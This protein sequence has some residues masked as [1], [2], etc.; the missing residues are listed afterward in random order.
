MTEERFICRAKGAEYRER[1]WGHEGVSKARKREARQAFSME[2]GSDRSI[3]GARVVEHVLCFGNQTR[4][5]ARRGSNGEVG[6][7]QDLWG[8]RSP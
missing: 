3:D 2:G 7:C 4:G 1:L 8:K 5:K 6:V